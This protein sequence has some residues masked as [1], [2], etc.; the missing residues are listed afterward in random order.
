MLLQDIISSFHSPSKDVHL[1]ADQCQSL[2]RMDILGYCKDSVT[3]DVSIAKRA[4]AYVVPMLKVCGSRGI[5]TTLS[6]THLATLDSYRTLGFT[7]LSLDS[8]SLTSGFVT[9][10]RPI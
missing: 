5:C 10:G 3:G 2:V 4:L 9:L 7:E 6:G 8:P 1:P